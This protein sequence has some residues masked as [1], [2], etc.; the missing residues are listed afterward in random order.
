MQI[1]VV[2]ES[3]DSGRFRAEAPPPFG[4]AVEG[5]SAEEAVANLRDR[6]AE[7]FSNGR[8]IVALDVPLPDESP[9]ATF[10]GHLQ[11]DTFLDDF[12]ASLAEYRQRRDPSDA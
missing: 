8:R 4:V 10:A 12:Q 2:V 11:D 1:P 6:I 9:W 7:E 5:R 3:L